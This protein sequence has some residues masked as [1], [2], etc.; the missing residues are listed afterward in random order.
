[1]DPI[2]LPELKKERCPRI[3][4]EDFLELLDLNK[5]KFQKPKM[6]VIDVRNAEE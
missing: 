1:M 6:L 3:S 5:T 4:G 2:P